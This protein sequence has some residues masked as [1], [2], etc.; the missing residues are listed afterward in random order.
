MI[1][2]ALVDF[3]GCLGR[4]LKVPKF[5]HIDFKTTIVSIGLFATFF[6][7][8]VGLYG[9][10]PKN[11]A[12]SVPKL[13]EG[14]RFAFGASVLGM[15][16]S[17]SL[18]ILHKLAGGDAEDDDVLTSIDDKMGT[19]VSTMQSPEDLVRQFME[20]KTF[21]KGQL[22]QINDSLSK[23]LVQLSQ[24]AT[25]EI[26]QALERVI[27]DFNE[28]LKTQFGENFKELNRACL[29]MVQWQDK[30]KAHVESSEK[31]LAQVISS[32]EKSSAAIKELNGMNQET[33]EVCQ[34][35]GGLI[36][37]YDIQVKTLATHLESCKNLGRQAGDFLA[38]TE[39]A[40][41]LS[42]Q[43]LT[44]FSGVIEKSVSKQ[45]ESLAQLTKDIDEQLPKA[46][47]EL[48]K[49]LTGITHEFAADYRS[50][51]KFIT[52]NK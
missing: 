42:S 40:I 4:F 37:T 29:N 12:Q 43:N 23:A 18:S 47:G 48:E 3:F 45:S 36:R 33:K 17:V 24:G 50:L 16:L 30:Y 34:Q 39:K 46:L 11:V 52:D 8:L 15:F 19:L 2:L 5:R 26:T 32:L 27:T 7:V 51:F 20:M 14:L 31:G 6:G 13:L 9:F 1:L 22:G 35:V 44:N 41:S 21:L 49:V 28:N 10:D 38:S 25:A